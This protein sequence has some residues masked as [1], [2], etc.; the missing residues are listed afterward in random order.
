MPRFFFTL[1]SELMKR[2]L[3]IDASLILFGFLLG[4][5]FGHYHGYLN[6][7]DDAKARYQ[8]LYKAGNFGE[9]QEP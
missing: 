2:T 5:C 7:H 3:I 4:Y 9:F 1:E 8:Q 6:S